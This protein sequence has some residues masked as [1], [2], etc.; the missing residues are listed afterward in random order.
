[1]SAL[2]HLR[3]CNDVSARSALTPKAAQK[4]TFENGREGPEADYDARRMI[5]GT[6][7]AKQVRPHS[8]RPASH[9]NLTTPATFQAPLKLTAGS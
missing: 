1:M 2:G 3:R 5:A 6:Q 8:L 9:N 4:Q 7:L